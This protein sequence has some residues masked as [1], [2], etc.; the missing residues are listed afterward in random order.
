MAA[1]FLDIAKAFDGYNHKI[2]LDKLFIYGIR[3]QVFNWFK[4]YLSDR[5]FFVSLSGS[6]SPD[7]TV[8]IGIPQ[9]SILGL[10]RF[11]IYINDLPHVSN[12]FS[13][14]FICG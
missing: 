1:V 8:N 14:T 9:G 11:V 7:K 3:G 5:K 13:T 10:I 2:L 6:S 12:L 4:S